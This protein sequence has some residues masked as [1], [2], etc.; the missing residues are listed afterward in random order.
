M[1]VLIAYTF[2]VAFTAFCVWTLWLQGKVLNRVIWFLQ[3]LPYGPWTFNRKIYGNARSACNTV[4]IIK[5]LGIVPQMLVDVGANNSQWAYWIRKTWS[6][7]IIH[8]FEPQQGC[9]PTGIVHTIALS[10]KAGSGQ[11]IGAGVSAYLVDGKGTQVKRFDE[12]RLV[13]RFPAILKIDAEHHTAAALRGFGNRLES[14]S[15]VVVEMCGDIHD[16]GYAGHQWEILDTMRKSG[17]D[18]FTLV[19]AGYDNGVTGVYDVCFWKSKQS[20]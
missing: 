7:I 15:V 8:S 11:I 14:F 6:A 9:Q 12:L 2:I 20:E 3:Q 16:D 4:S 17:F 5:Q 10:D 18:K 19:D 13:L 1:I